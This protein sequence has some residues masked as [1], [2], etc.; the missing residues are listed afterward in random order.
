MIDNR[1][2]KRSEWEQ[3]QEY[4]KQLRDLPFAGVDIEQPIEVIV[5]SETVPSK[6]VFV[7]NTLTDDKIFS[8]MEY[9]KE[10]EYNLIP[11]ALTSEQI[12]IISRQILHYNYYADYEDYQQDDPQLS[13]E[14]RLSDE[15]DKRWTRE[16]ISGIFGVDFRYFEPILRLADVREY[17]LKWVK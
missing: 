1:I 6:T 12:D 10:L 14:Y 11:N 17:Y 3:L 2:F 13:E 7:F 8:A 4:L 16:V 5:E 15:A 9:A